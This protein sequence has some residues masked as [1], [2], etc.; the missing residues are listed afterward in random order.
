MCDLNGCGG[1]T[2]HTQHTEWGGWGG[3]IKRFKVEIKV[4]ETMDDVPLPN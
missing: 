3:G 2:S 4:R 1:Y